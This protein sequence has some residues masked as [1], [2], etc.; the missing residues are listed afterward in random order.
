MVPTATKRFSVNSLQIL[1]FTNAIFW[2]QILKRS[3][4]LSLLQLRVP[5]QQEPPSK[6]DPGSWRWRTSSVAGAKSDLFQLGKKHVLGIAQVRFYL[7]LW[8]WETASS[9]LTLSSGVK[10]SPGCRQPAGRV[11]AP[12]AVASLGFASPDSREHQWDAD[13]TARVAAE[14]LQSEAGELSFPFA[15][16]KSTF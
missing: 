1:L 15:K 10:E 9:A 3:S 12:S 5:L 6:S 2:T 16:V 11:T 13:G 7:H 4:V 14:R 8:R